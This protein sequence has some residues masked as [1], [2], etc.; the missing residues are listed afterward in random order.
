[1]A[2]KIDCPTCQLSIRSNDFFR[3]SQ[4]HST[5]PAKFHCDWPE[6]DYSAIQKANLTAHRNRMHLKIRQQCPHCPANYSD[7]SSL[8]KHL[9]KEHEYAPYHTQTWRESRTATEHVV[10]ESTQPRG[11][12]CRARSEP[13]PM[14]AAPGSSTRLSAPPP[15]NRTSSNPSPSPLR[16][17][18]PRLCR[19]DSLTPLPLPASSPNSDHSLEYATSSHF[20]V[21]SLASQDTCYCTAQESRSSEHSQILGCYVN[22]FSVDSPASFLPANPIAD[23]SVYLPSEH[24]FEFDQM[25]PH[26]LA[27]SQVGDFTDD[28]PQGPSAWY[29]QEVPIPPPMGHLP[30]VNFDWIANAEGR[31]YGAQS[32][33]E[34]LRVPRNYSM[35]SPSSLPSCP[36]P[37]VSN[38]LEREP[39]GYRPFSSTLTSSIFGQATDPFHGAEELISVLESGYV[40]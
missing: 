34:P 36:A 37:D 14:T 19:S 21:P 29:R 39:T 15:F 18:L 24:D 30:D 27:F 17:I 10:G 6:C 20:S 3:H 2:D 8:I 13:Y 33:V 1:M 28:L 7:R 5:N 40:P 11:R 35:P 9:K 22:Q 23:I 12:T 32:P 38:A 31:T 26:N 4:T 25:S 16:P